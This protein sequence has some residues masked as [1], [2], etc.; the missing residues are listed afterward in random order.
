MIPRSFR[1][2][3]MIALAVST[4]C[5]CSEGAGTVG[6]AGSAESLGPSDLRLESV[7]T[8][9]YL[10][11][12]GDV[13]LQV[14]LGSDIDPSQVEVLSNGD[15]VT[16]HFKKRHEGGSLVGLAFGVA[17]TLVIFFEC[18]LSWRKKVPAAPL[19]RLQTWLRAH[20]WLGLLSFV[21][22]VFHAGFEWGEGLAS[23]LMWL[24]VVIGVSGIYGLA[25]QQFLPRGEARDGL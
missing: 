3:G 4:V 8:R 9:S 23:V 5:A 12:G 10:V 14:D 21:L 25:L 22:I 6:E 1:A 19:G 15:D 18:L 16:K 7:S 2:V 11:T 24:F 20:I 13:L 17:G